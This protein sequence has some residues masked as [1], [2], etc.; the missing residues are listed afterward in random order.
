VQQVQQKEPSNS[1]PEGGANI[2]RHMGLVTTLAA[3]IGGGAWL[4]YRWD[5]ASGHEVAWGTALC[6]LLGMAASFTSVFRSL[7]K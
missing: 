5:Q 2:M 7:S 4:G 1:R 6:A 3:G